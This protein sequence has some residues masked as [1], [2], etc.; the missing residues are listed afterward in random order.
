MSIVAMIEKSFPVQHNLKKELANIS[1]FTAKFVPR[2]TQEI[3]AAIKLVCAE[4]SS[5][6]SDNDDTAIAYVTTALQVLHAKFHI[7]DLARRTA[8]EEI[9][10]NPK[11]L[12]E[13]KK[14]LF[15]VYPHSVSPSFAEN[16]EHIVKRYD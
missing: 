8:F 10:A 7:K 9:R 5:I 4:I 14:I 3:D 2:Y 13:V 15:V 12:K 16:V 11:I 6:L 1:F